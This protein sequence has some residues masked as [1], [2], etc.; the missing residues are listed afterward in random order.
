MAV[1]LTTRKPVVDLAASDLRRFPVWEYA[2]GEEGTDGQDETWVRPIDSAAIPKDEY[3]QIVAA[4]FWTATGQSVE[5]FMIVTTAKQP[6]EIDP[7]ALVGRFGYCVLPSISRDEAQERNAPWQT[8]ARDAV[9]F[10]LGA[11]EEEVFPI[12]F[13]LRVTVQGETQKREGTVK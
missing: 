12:R 2:L 8:K 13:C 4:D 6:I 5:G 3:S 1:S 7:G 9:V 11:A 10:A